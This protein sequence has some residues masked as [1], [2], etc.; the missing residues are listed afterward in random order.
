MTEIKGIVV[1]IGV[2]FF[3]APPCRL[4]TQLVDVGGIGVEAKVLRTFENWWTPADP[5]VPGPLSLDPSDREGGTDPRQQ[6]T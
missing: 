5:L 4:L 3:S 1:Q 6:L 2:G